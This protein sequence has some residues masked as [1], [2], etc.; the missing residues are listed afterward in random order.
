MVI[1]NQLISVAVLAGIDTVGSDTIVVDTTRI[2]YNSREPVIIIDPH[3]GEE[4]KHQEAP[5]QGPIFDYYTWLFDW[6]VTWVIFYLP[7]SILYPYHIQMNTSHIPAY[8][9]HIRDYLRH[10]SKKKW[11]SRDSNPESRI[12][13]PLPTWPNEDH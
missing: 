9:Y 5:K 8:T 10:A 13:A 6:L 1:D 2:T 3:T 7:H 4:R 12:K 11:S